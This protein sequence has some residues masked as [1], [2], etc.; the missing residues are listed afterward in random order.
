MY[1]LSCSSCTHTK[2]FPQILIFLPALWLYE[3]NNQKTPETGELWGFI[4]FVCFIFYLYQSHFKCLLVWQVLI[5]KWL[6]ACDARQ[7]ELETVWQKRQRMAQ[8]SDGPV[9]EDQGTSEQEG[10]LSFW[11]GESRNREFNNTVASAILVGLRPVLAFAS[12]LP[13]PVTH[14]VWP[15]LRKKGRRGFHCLSPFSSP[16]GVQADAPL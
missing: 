10:R 3:E 12:K 4:L 9:R 5:T 1:T 7:R 11:G 14:S 13:R 6:Y 8:N 16:P 2:L 15:Q